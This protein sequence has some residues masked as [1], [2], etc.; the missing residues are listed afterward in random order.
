MAT[1]KRKINSRW[2]EGAERYSEK[3]T[4]ETRFYL[5]GDAVPETEALKSYA[6]PKGWHKGARCVS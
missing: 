4:A 3:R 2:R 5:T 6:E 1:P